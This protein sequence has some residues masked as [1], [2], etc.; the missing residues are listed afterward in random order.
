MYVLVRLGVPL[1]RAVLSYGAVG[2]VAFVIS[3]VLELQSRASFLQLLASHEGSCHGA[4]NWVDKQQQQQQ[5]QKL[6]ELHDTEG[7]SKAGNT[8]KQQQAGDMPAAGC[9]KT[10]A[11][12]LGQTSPPQPAAA[13]AAQAAPAAQ[14]PAASPAHTAN[15]GI[16]TQSSSARAGDSATRDLALA[17]LARLLGPGYQQLLDA[18]PGAKATEGGASKMLS[19]YQGYCQ[20]YQI[21]IKVR[22][23]A[24]TATDN[25]KARNKVPRCLLCMP[26]M[27]EPVLMTGTHHS[28]S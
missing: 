13:A 19:E 6:L 3:A 22:Q 27:L 25:S 1:Q 12:S 14:T 28:F 15:T 18:A 10:H 2:L 26:N 11:E 9:Q 17:E 21:G 24:D 7:A 5:K 20:I 23:E 16:S 8:H 4:G